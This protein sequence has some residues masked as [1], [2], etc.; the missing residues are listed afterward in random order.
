MMDRSFAGRSFRRGPF[1][2]LLFLGAFFVFLQ[3]GVVRAASFQVDTNGTLTANLLSYYATE[4]ANDSYASNNLTANG[5]T[6]FVAGKVN[7]A[8][9]FDGTND[10]LDGGNTFAFE[11][12]DHFSFSVWVNKN[13]GGPFPISKMN[14]TNDNGWLLQWQGSGGGNHFV[15]HL[16]NSA[17]NKIQVTTNNVFSST[18]TWYHVVVTYDGSATAA[19]VHIYVNGTDQTLT[20]NVDALTLST[21]FTNAFRIGESSD[22]IGD[23]NGLIDEVGIWNKVLSSQEIAD[24]YNSNSG[25]QFFAGPHISGTLGQYK[26]DATTTIAM[27]GKTDETTVVFGANISAASSSG[28]AQLQ[29]EVKPAGTYFTNTST[30]TSGSVSSGGYATTSVS[31]L[32]PG[33][34]YHW[35]ARVLDGT[36]ATSSWQYAFPGDTSSSIDFIVDPERSAYFNGSSAWKWPATNLG[37]NSTNPFTIEFFYK[38]EATSSMQFIDT[39]TGDKNG[40]ALWRDSSGVNF[41]L[42]CDNSTTTIRVAG[43]G[44]VINRINPNTGG[45]YN[46]WHHVAIT[47]GTTASSTDAFKLYVDG[48]QQT[49]DKCYTSTS[50][51]SIWI[52]GNPS[53]SIGLFNGNIDEVRIWNTERSSSSIETYS[54][55][56]VTSTSSGLKG[57]RRFNATSTDLVTGNATSGQSG[58]PTFSTSTPF[59]HFILN[60]TTY[61]TSVNT[62]TRELKW[63]AS[64]TYSTEWLNAISAWNALGKITFASTTPSS[65]AYLKVVDIDEP[66]Q[67]FTGRWAYFLD[68]DQL[69]FN[70]PKLVGGTSS[71]TQKTATHELG[72]ALGLDH[73]FFGN[74]MYYIQTTQTWLGNHDVG[75]FNYFWP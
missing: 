4:N 54:G 10:N 40:F 38:T 59:G 62:S 53:S 18:G 26:S 46:E 27:G 11:K 52:G 16:G 72:H 70:L 33:V 9:S 6:S 42:N 12:T 73:S 22:G 65:T 25:D 24:L 57:Y 2:A 74:V 50:T 63:H 28:S 37:F 30:T 43:A 68:P 47:K 51:D 69:Q 61:T 44:S 49:S 20:T 41:S 23:M 39:R 15:F 19:G 58:S 64:T 17:S 8:A 35:Q 71:S 32:S 7:N 29:V 14:A 60:Q 5:D 1:V 3:T 67:D 45:V 21:V 56:E 55:Q 31:N 66:D 75:D 34:S 13:S 36:G 48:G